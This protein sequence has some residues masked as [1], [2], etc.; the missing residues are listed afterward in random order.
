M[1]LTGQGGPGPALREQQRVAQG[2]PPPGFLGVWGCNLVTSV[3]PST[4][5]RAD[6]DVAWPSTEHMHEPHRPR[7]GYGLLTEEEGYRGGRSGH[8]PTHSDSR[9]P[10]S[11][12]CSQSTYLGPGHVPS[13]RA[14]PPSLS[15]ARA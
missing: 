14:A 11:G 15:Q 5:S 12:F 3:C 2:P 7:E 13:T 8:K 9:G 4:P 1:A 6:T 10:S